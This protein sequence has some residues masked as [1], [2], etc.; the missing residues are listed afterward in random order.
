M[1]V[2]VVQCFC[3]PSSVLFYSA[4]LGYIRVYLLNVG[5]I[6]LRNSF[7]ILVCC[8]TRGGRLE[9]VHEIF[10]HVD[11]RLSTSCHGEHGPASP[12]L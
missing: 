4:L 7:Y 5:C 11:D 2:D 10:L 8:D 12:L 3:I 9:N 6:M 1:P